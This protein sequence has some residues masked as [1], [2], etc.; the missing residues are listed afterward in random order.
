MAQK[1]QDAHE[2]R[3]F[4]LAAQTAPDHFVMV[5]SE[6]EYWRSVSYQERNN[7]LLLAETIKIIEQM[8]NGVIDIIE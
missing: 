4:Q 8:K 2:R 3:H 5:L 7:N 1:V 6:P